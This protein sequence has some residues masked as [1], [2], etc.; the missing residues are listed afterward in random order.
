[1]TNA[2]V[3]LD[4]M[5]VFH[6][7]DQ[8]FL[9]DRGWIQPVNMLITVPQELIDRQARIFAEFEAL[10]TELNQLYDQQRDSLKRE[11]EGLWDEHEGRS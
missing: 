2:R 4:Q 11:L 10:Q 7:I 9:D 6:L 3:E 5:T 1:M 8:K